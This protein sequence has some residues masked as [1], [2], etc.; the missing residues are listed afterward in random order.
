M[1]V[2]WL[3]T[4]IFRSVLAK[5]L[6]LWGGGGEVLIQLDNSTFISHA[7]VRRHQPMPRRGVVHSKPRASSLAM[8]S[9]VS[10]LV[11]SFSACFSECLMPAQN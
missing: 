2:K 1:M 11:P 9:T 8:R 5:K 6:E 3:V 10:F 7:Q 4:A